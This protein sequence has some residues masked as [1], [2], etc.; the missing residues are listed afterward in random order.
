MAPDSQ[1]MMVL[2]AGKLPWA[3]TLPRPLVLGPVRQALLLVSAQPF[4]SLAVA[5]SLLLVQAS[6][7]FRSSV[8]AAR[9][10]TAAVTLLAAQM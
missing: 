4:R 10:S 3:Q 1:Q 9:S 7:H 8:S 6:R 2:P 5:W